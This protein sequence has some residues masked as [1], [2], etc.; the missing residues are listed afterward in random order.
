MRSLS[1]ELDATLDGVLERGGGVSQTQ[2]PSGATLNSMRDSIQK[3]CL[4]IIKQRTEDSDRLLREL[5]KIR[6]DHQR[7][8]RE[9][10]DTA[11]RKHKLKK[12][13]KREPDENRPLAVGAHGVARQDGVDVHKGGG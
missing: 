3:R 8:E 10:D 12:V 11:E 1:K 9:R 13:K 5:Q 4:E 7:V 2:V 6:R